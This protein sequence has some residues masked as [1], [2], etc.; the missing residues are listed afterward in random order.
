MIM[1]L[2]VPMRVARASAGVILLLLYSSVWLMLSPTS[3]HRRRLEYLGWNALLT[4]FGIRVKISGQAAPGALLVSNHI[5]WID[6]VALA[7]SCDASFVA[8]REV[9]GW[10]VIGWLARRHGC[11]FINRGW[12]R[13]VRHEASQ[14]RSKLLEGRDLVIFAEGTTSMG[15]DV[16]PFRS[17]L[18]AAAID[19]DCGI[20]QPV[21][22]SYLNSDGSSQNNDERRAVAWLGDDTLLPHALTLAARGGTVVQLWF[23]PVLKSHDRKELAAAARTAIQNHLDQENHAARLKRA[24]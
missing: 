22:I 7:H 21:A 13:G 10:P 24:A 23:G 4:G 2:I 1:T 6:I 9:G 19:T 17:S 16:L 11:I 15:W 8:K 5:S 18:L 14:I 12:R 20:I 3:R